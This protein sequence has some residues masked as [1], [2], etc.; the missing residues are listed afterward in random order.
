MQYI[1]SSE[2]VSRTAPMIFKYTMTQFNLYVHK[3]GLKLHSFY[4][5]I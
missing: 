3:G 4:F 5:E 1:R 2:I